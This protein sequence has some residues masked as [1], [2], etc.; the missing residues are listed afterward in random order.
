MSDLVRYEVVDR[1][2]VLVVDNPPVNA[3][4]PAARDALDHN[5]A[6]AASDNA[7]DAMVLIGAGSTFIAGGD[8]K[9]FDTLRTAADSMRRSENTHALLRRMEDSPK[10]VVAAI[11]GNALGG[12][13]E[14]AMACHYRV[15]SADAKLGQP[16][17]LLGLIPGAAGTQRLPRL[18]GP[19]LAMRMCTDGKPISAQEALA[20]GLVDEIA[21]GD[22]RAKAIRFARAC[23]AR[24]ARR[25]TRELT[26]KTLD[27]TRAQE[28]AQTIRKALAK[29]AKGMRAPYAA[30]EAIEY[31][32]E[33]TFDEG[34]LRERELFAECVV[35]TES[36]ALRHLF[37]AEREVAK[38]PD[39]PRD[40]PT[41][42]IGCAAIVGAGTMGGGI[43]MTYA[44]A[45][46]PVLLRDV[47]ETALERGMAMI[48]K[49]YES[50]VAKGKMTQDALAKTLALITPTT[51]YDG[52]ERADIVVEAVFED[53]DLKRTTFAE[54]S[55]VTR[56]DCILASNT[57]TLDI[58]ALAAASGR[59]DKVLGHHFFSPAQ[60]MKLLEIV[61]GRHTDAQTIA[62]SLKLAKRLGKV[63][64]VVGNCFGFVANRMLAYYMR[65][66]YLLL[67]E[68]A[69][70]SQIDSAL[71]DFGMPMGPFAMQDVAGIDVSARIRQYLKSI[72]KTRAEGPQSEVM[73]RL[74][75]LGRYG[76]KTGVGWYRYEQGSR[77]PIADPLIDGLAAREAARRGV[78]RRTIADEEIIA[79]VTT[80]LANEGARVLGEGY[81]LRPGD[82]DVI[83]AYG[84]GFP[85]YRG[86]PL[87]Y[88][89]TI[90]LPTVLRRVAEYRARFG[91]YWTPA[92]LLERLV[93]EGRG[94]YDATSVG[95]P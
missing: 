24:G 9:L 5:V 83:Y 37:F 29:T 47:D 92:P 19:E 59:P 6:R 30:L 74:Y 52:F 51:G 22:L 67:E 28:A 78:T 81:A 27:K 2:A 90:G 11:H 80:A 45:G 94:F 17:V 71:T 85:R 82:I 43:A 69:T 20:A 89:D 54:L 40:T 93:A 62:M 7:I 13:N 60:V 35:S 84:F 18:V 61:R 25:K 34:S 3:L 26:D 1:V 16:E 42:A 50:A 14:V 41:R 66:A 58:D 63:G 72:G 77:T 10:P 75:E 73:D 44:N 49:N 65:E 55:R 33:H 95:G 21:S 31:G 15:V 68:G 46:I 39:V 38:I 70:A 32:V 36:K 12:G 4:S 23:A 64:V 76:Q 86:G 79:R 53:L 87:F 8:I 91:N 48:R 56:P 57:S 88:S